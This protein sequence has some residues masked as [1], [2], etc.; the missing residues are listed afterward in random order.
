MI[1][2]VSSSNVV[3]GK[4]G[5]MTM[6]TANHPV[7][8]LMEAYAQLVCKQSGKDIKKLLSGELKKTFSKARGN[9]KNPL[10]MIIVPVFPGKE[11][12]LNARIS[13]LTQYYHELRDDIFFLILDVSG[14]DIQNKIPTE[15]F[16]RPDVFLF[17]STCLSRA[18]DPVNRFFFLA[19][20]D[21][22]F[23]WVN[24]SVNFHSDLVANFQKLKKTTPLLALMTPLSDRTVSS[25][26]PK[27]REAP[28]RD[29]TVI[30]S[31]L[32]ELGLDN[33]LAAFR[34][35]RQTV[36][37]INAEVIKK[38]R[39]EVISRSGN[40]KDYWRNQ[41]AEL[42][43]VQAISLGN[44]MD[45]DS[46]IDTPDDS[47]DEIIV[48][49]QIQFH[50][51]VILLKYYKKQL[52]RSRLIFQVIHW[53]PNDTLAGGTEKHSRDLSRMHF[54]FGGFSCEIF[55]KGK[56]YVFGF[57]LDGERITEHRLQ[58][59]DVAPL[60][61][62]L[63]DEINLAHFHH[64]IN[65]HPAVIAELAAIDFRLKFASLHDFWFLCPSITL[66]KYDK[67]T[68]SKEYC[69]LP[70]SETCMACY[71]F[72]FGG[73]TVGTIDWHLI[74][75]VSIL[76]KMHRIFTPSASTARI[77]QKGLRGFPEVAAKIETREHDLSY[78]A[79][80]I[81]EK[82]PVPTPN[83][84]VAFLGR[85]YNHKG[86]NEISVIAHK[87]IENGYEVKIFGDLIDNEVPLDRKYVQSFRGMDELKKLLGEYAPS[88]VG[89]VH[90]WPETFCYTFYESIAICNSAI[91]VVSPLG[92]P[93]DVVDCEKFGEKLEDFTVDEFYA[94][95]E[96]VL[97]NHSAYHDRK[98]QFLAKIP[99][100][101]EQY[102]RGFF[103][104]ISSGPDVDYHSNGALKDRISLF[105]PYE[106][107]EYSTWE[108]FKLYYSGE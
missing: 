91:P 71:N 7:S 31:V 51:V 50:A 5:R 102:Y 103:G 22:D 57:V 25:A 3:E 98:H 43:F 18:A 104:E 46:P 77:Y 35:T 27:G 66:L 24:E 94:K 65:W 86:S 29:G 13:I 39:E 70:D 81:D 106:K 63:K 30:Q 41:V 19:D 21:V 47:S 38:N 73:A 28:K 92:N 54:R 33:T 105:H 26:V 78:L 97:K 34:H 72:S 95:C 67:T 56:G 90:I 42:G 79:K 74:H 11:E 85:L 60:L 58:P 48:D 32:E 37:F 40:L 96:K 99:D 55:P 17:Q 10:S 88:V 36:F 15:V 8:S 64:G 107:K 61:R 12:T 44:Y 20:F 89:F 82:S 75:S 100:N 68:K 1:H 93:A 49:S 83:K 101:C 87:L 76:S 53:D 9:P 45:F 62:L 52:S 14:G 4:F 80:Y 108:R 2:E 84:R 69:G 23:L 6:S 16:R 59:R